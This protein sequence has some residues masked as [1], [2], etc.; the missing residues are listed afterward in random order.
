MMAQNLEGQ[1]NFM[2]LGLFEE[3]SSVAAVL[4]G[5]RRIGVPD[6]RVSIMSTVPYSPRIL[7][8]RPTRNYLGILTILGALIGLTLALLF[9]V[10]TPLLYPLHVGGQPLIP[11][12]PTLII[13]F[14]LTMLGTMWVTFGGFFLLNR[15][16]H[17]GNPVYDAR[18]GAGNIGVAVETDES[19]VDRAADLLKNG[20]AFDV[21]R[22]P[23]REQM[24]KRA[25]GRWLLVVGLIAL[26]VGVITPLFVYDVIRIPFGTQMDDQASV[27]YQGA[28]RLAAPA[29]AVPF[30]GPAFIA[31]Q[32]ATQPIPASDNS[33]QRGQVLYGIHCA[34]CHGEQGLGDGRLSGF[35][36]PKPFNLTSAEV[37][38][39]PDAQIFTVISNGFGIMPPLRENLTP[40][41]RWDV[42][43]YVRALKK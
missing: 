31:S 14:E 23:A 7:G 24:D 9:M 1:R 33:R 18:I 27:P 8:R 4:E 35:F 22:M 6:N 30:T 17:F 43:N 19:R 42:V 21:Q 12:P 15:F 10:G 37:Q 26:A 41:E 2:L 36:N 3:V 20:G 13:V 11:I 40:E 32:P 16:P 38:A 39:L 28:P 29:D 5:L 34:L 25:W